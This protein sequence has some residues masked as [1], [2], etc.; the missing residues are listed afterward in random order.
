M[1]LSRTQKTIWCLILKSLMWTHKLI[2]FVSL[3]SLKILCQSWQLTLKEALLM[4][5]MMNF[6]KL[7][8]IRNR[9]RVINEIIN[10]PMELGLFSVQLLTPLGEEMISWVESVEMTKWL[11]LKWKWWAERV[12]LQ[13]LDNR[14]ELLWRSLS[15]WTKMTTETKELTWKAFSS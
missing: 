1:I 15:T 12:I 9:I 7:M 3:I 11:G 2:V 14:Q 8:K 6:L 10:L 5:S 4:A 13:V